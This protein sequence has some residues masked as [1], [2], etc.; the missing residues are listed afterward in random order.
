MSNVG[1][2]ALAAGRAVRAGLVILVVLVGI[3]VPLV[4]LSGS[5][6]AG[7]EPSLVPVEVLA[8]GDPRSE[9]GG[10]GLVGSPIV[11][12]LGVVALGL[13]TAA[14]TALIATLSRRR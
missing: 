9:G 4:V 3:V 1:P 2:G 8:G 12:L 11:V 13:G 14:V 6:V 5:S 10:P 7:A